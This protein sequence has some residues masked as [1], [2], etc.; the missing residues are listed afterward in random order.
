MDNGYDIADYKDIDP[1]LGTMADF[2]HLL[3]RAVSRF[4]NDSEKYRV[5][6]AKMLGTCLHMMQGTPYVYEGEELGMTN[7]DFTEISEYR[8]PEA[9]DIYY[10]SGG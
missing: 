8:D 6:S 9:L 10:A 2:E 5:I 4:G 7:A 3:A 1:S